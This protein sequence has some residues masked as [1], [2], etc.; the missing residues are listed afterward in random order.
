MSTK[1]GVV[2]EGS[3]NGHAAAPCLPPHSVRRVPKGWKGHKCDIL[4]GGAHEGRS[5][6]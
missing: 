2:D 5:W 1:G 3:W 4:T 6:S